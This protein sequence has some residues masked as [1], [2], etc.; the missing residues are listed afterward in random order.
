MHHNPLSDRRQ[1]NDGKN[2]TKH[3]KAV[4]TIFATVA[5]C[6]LLAAL[7]LRHLLTVLA[8]DWLQTA[9]Q[10]RIDADRDRTLAP[11]IE[12]IQRVDEMLNDPS[13][14]EWLNAPEDA[15]RERAA[16]D[17]LN[18]FRREL[19]DHSYFIALKRTGGYFHN[20]ES[21]EYSGRE[22]LYKLSADNAND[23]WFF[24]GLE[25]DENVTLNVDFDRGIG[26]VKLWIN[27]RIFDADGPA[28]IAGTGFDLS[29]FLSR[30]VRSSAAGFQTFFTNAAG[31]IQLSP[32]SG[33]IQYG[34]LG[35]PDGARRTLF[36]LTD[37]APQS[38]LLQ[39]LFER[40]SHLDGNVVTGTLSLMGQESLVGVAYF[41]FLDW[42][43]V[44]YTQTNRLI[45]RD[46]TL[47]LYLVIT[48]AAFL[49]MSLIWWSISRSFIMPLASLR[50]FAA[51]AKD[52][53]SNV[54]SPNFDHPYQPVSEAIMTIRDL[55]QQAAM[56]SQQAQR[57]LAAIRHTLSRER[58]R[59]E[60][61]GLLTET[62]F[63]TTLAAVIA[64]SR[65]VSVPVSLFVFRPYGALSPGTEL[66][67]THARDVLPQI[68]RALRASVESEGDFLGQLQDGEF[69]VLMPGLNA[70]KVSEA[71]AHLAAALQ[72][73]VIVIPGTEEAL[74]LSID[75]GVETANRAEEAHPDVLI[76]RAEQALHIAAH[77]RSVRE[78][79]GDQAPTP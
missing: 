79:K 59:D 55:G 76:K 42:Y 23:R 75:Y 4:L 57:D 50:Q 36:D 20:N 2:V 11:I 30:Y 53:V 45:S 67:A 9:A 6:A 61:T 48:F 15:Q 39:A 12:E 7:G 72:R 10:I 21:G 52:P 73:T 69:A 40:A 35:V 5:L 26:V 62:S 27:R 3:S 16:L 70:L 19:H 71:C 77:Q 46:A 24:A 22:L 63:K 47:Q 32:N 74:Q 31:A 60:V 34:S 43:A 44:T 33:D 28:G 65:R 68:G 56:E 51:V 41:P 38:Q 29:S 18:G 1:N 13:I 58:M 14:K 8:D 54:S 17:F 37:S 66:W 78:A 25:L 49:C 64:L